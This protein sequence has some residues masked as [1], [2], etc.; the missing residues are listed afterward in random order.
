MRSKLR[1]SYANVMSSIAVFI[2]LGGGAY[3]ATGGFVSGTGAIKGCV[4]KH[5]GA[6][7]VVKSG[8][9]CP[10]GTTALTFSQAGPAGAPGAP[11]APGAAGK[12][13]P[14]GPA[15]ISGQT[16]WGNVLIAPGGSDVTV[17]TVGP[18]VLRAHCPVSGKGEY[19]LTD[20]SGT[21]ELYG[22]DEGY[23]EIPAGEEVPVADDE[24]YDEAFYAWSP[25]TGVS[26]NGLPFHWNAEHGGGN[27]EF[28]G[29]V[30]QTS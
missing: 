13:G 1:P 24:D 30:T 8:K 6:L 18:F 28:Q 14:Q 10:K 17:A 21:S 20:A 3:A 22:E 16:R 15:G 23:G 26:L 29:S 25:S 5:G 9:K 2:A 4:S 11:G 12:E 27:C 19:L 7:R